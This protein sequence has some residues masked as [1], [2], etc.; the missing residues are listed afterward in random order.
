[1]MRHRKAY[2]YLLPA[3]VIFSLVIVYPIGS[4]LGTSVWK[5]GFTLEHYRNVI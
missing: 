4:T 2:L 3:L 5:N 1:M